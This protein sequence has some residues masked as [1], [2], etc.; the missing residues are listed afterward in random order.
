MIW[1][2]SRFGYRRPS[3]DSDRACKLQRI[4]HQMA[5]TKSR[6][7]GP[8]RPGLARAPM[9]CDVIY[10]SKIVIQHIQHIMIEVMNHIK[11]LLKSTGISEYSF[12]QDDG[13]VTE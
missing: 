9:D 12:S 6:Q 5:A 10:H 8:L 2:E 4:E 13:C 7:H 1:W 11:V 3:K